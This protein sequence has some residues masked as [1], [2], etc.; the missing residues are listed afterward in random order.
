MPI[1]ETASARR[2]ADACTLRAAIQETNAAPGADTITLPAGTYVL[3]IQGE[4]ED[5][6]AAGDLDIT[7]HLTIIG[8]G[9]G[10]TIVDG[11]GVD[12]ILH[13]L[14]G[15]PSGTAAQVSGV[16]IRNGRVDGGGGGISS[17]GTLTLSDSVVERNRAENRLGSGG[18]IENKGELILTNSIVRDNTAGRTGGGIDNFGVSH[19]LLTNS[20]VTGNMAQSNGGAI[21]TNGGTVTLTDSAVEGNTGRMGGGIFIFNFS[22]ARLTLVSSAVLGNRAALDGGGISNGGSGRGGTVDIT[23][24]TIEG[25]SAAGA[26]SGIDNTGDLTVTRSTV[27]GNIAEAGGGALSNSGTATLTNSTVSGTTSARGSAGILNVGALSLTN[28]TVSNNDQGIIH[29]GRA[30]TLKNSI[31]AGNSGADC[32]GPL[33]SLGN[34][35]DSDNSCTLA[36]S[37]DLSGVSPLLGPLADNGGPTQTHA[38]LRGS[39]AIDTGDDVA[40]PPSDQRG[41]PRLG[42][43]DVGAYEFQGQEVTL[44]EGWNLVAVTE[45]TTIADATAHL[46]G[47]F[48]IV[49]AYDTSTGTF[50]AFVS[51]D[52]PVL[53]KPFELEAG[54]GLMFFMNRPD[55]WVQPIPPDAIV[56]SLVVGA[57]LIGWTG[58][59]ASIRE[60]LADVDGVRSVL[61][62][63]P[64]GS[65]ASN[66]LA[67]SDDFNSLL[68]LETGV[69]YWVQMG[70]PATLTIPGHGLRGAGPGDLLWRFGYSSPFVDARVA[71]AF[72]IL[73]D[74]AAVLAAAEL[75][76][77]TALLYADPDVPALAAR[78]RDDALLLLDAAGYGDGF[79]GFCQISGHTAR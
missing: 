74:N 63:N 55:M 72:D 41:R 6:A 70:G 27:S 35:L 5:A 3:A 8:A 56:R 36:A 15:P 2:R 38:L 60:A 37:G 34:N 1:P 47:A 64:D 11:N 67:L 52:H 13:I 17:D 10:S 79:V 40:A 18:G 12:R 25:N 9:A 76:P 32:A 45:A 21:F 4:P 14:A 44:Q 30:A 20:A 65:F 39:P 53:N 66:I 57:N 75:P 62:V 73:I 71:A 50:E 16:T 48:D 43:S 46:V 29:I 77:D 58:P 78:A 54:D 7:D 61:T 31:V 49:F 22:P 42:P 69:A 51:L 28:S 19:L 24:S 68:T 23:D 26:G 59:A 33:V